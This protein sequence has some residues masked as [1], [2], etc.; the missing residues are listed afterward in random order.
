[1]EKCF[2]KWMSIGIVICLLSFLC[3]HS[4]EA[5]TKHPLVGNW[6]LVYKKG[7]RPVVCYKLL[8]K[9]GSY[10]NLKSTDWDGKYYEVSHQGMYTIGKGQYAEIVEEEHGKKYFP[11]VVFI[12]N[13]EFVGKDTLKVTYRING[14]RGEE[15]WHKTKKAPRY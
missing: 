8:K 6:T 10:V 5:K 4:V 9:D 15:V 7:D 3:V 13:Y 14:Q 11:P 2:N 12:L 1:M